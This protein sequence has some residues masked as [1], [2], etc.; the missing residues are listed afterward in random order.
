MPSFGH[1]VT[2]SRADGLRRNPAPRSR[3][4]SS[5]QTARGS[6]RPSAP[7]ATAG[8]IDID[9]L[10]CR[11]GHAMIGVVGDDHPGSAGV[12]RGQGGGRGHSPRTRCR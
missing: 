10:G 12:P 9:S 8:P 2:G 6:E 4:G 7:G 3:R 1:P 5:A 11:K